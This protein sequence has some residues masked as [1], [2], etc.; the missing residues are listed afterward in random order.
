MA[1]L[2]AEQF[3]NFFR[4]FKGTE[5]QVRGAWRLYEAIQKADPGIL[6]EQQALWIQEYRKQ[7]AP[8]VITPGPGHGPYD[9]SGS[10]EA[11]MIGP[12]KHPT[13]HKL[14]QMSWNEIWSRPVD[15][16]VREEFQFYRELFEMIL[17]D[18]RKF[19]AA[20]PVLLEGA[21]FLPELV[22]KVRPQPQR[23]LYLVPTKAFQIDHYAQRPFIQGILKECD[24]PE[25]AFANWME[26]DHLFGQE[27]L[28]QAQEFGYAT[29]IVDG[30]RS[31][32]HHFKFVSQYFGFS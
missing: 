22:A 29:I 5:E 4:Y 13:M 20:R 17:Q 32:E 25:R 12:Q 8:T 31:V 14:A 10:E 27:I 21:A 3:A 18:L 30:N 9:P 15:D 11:G 1:H 2:T 26:R 7:A 23:V 24:D 16:Q 19:S 6:D 28:K